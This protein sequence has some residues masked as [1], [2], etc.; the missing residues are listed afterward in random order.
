MERT[1]FLGILA[2]KWPEN[3]LYIKTSRFPSSDKHLHFFKSIKKW[4]I[5]HELPW[6]TIFGVTSEVI[7]Q[8]LHAWRSHDWKVLANCI[9]SD[10]KIVIHGN[11]CIISFLTRYFL[12]LNAQFRQKQSSVADFAIVAKGGLFWFSIVTS[13]QLICDFTRMRVTGTVAS[14]SSIVLSRANWRKGDVH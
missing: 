9:T 8:K 14:F 11:E 12:S 1:P 2:I 10:P 3:S 4:R 13:L 5:M 6:I 7:F